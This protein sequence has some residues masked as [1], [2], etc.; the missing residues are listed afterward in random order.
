LFIAHSVSTSACAL[1]MYKVCQLLDPT[2]TSLILA[3]QIPA[4]F[5]LQYT[6]FAGLH[7]GHINGVGIS[8]ACLVFTGNIFVLLY[9]L[10]K[11]SCDSKENTETQ[12]ET[13]NNK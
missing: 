1:M 5:V 6:G 13:N 7:P 12:K 2:V 4:A 8:G 10:T 9:H 11:V 3:S